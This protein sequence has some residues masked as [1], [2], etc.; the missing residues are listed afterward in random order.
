MEI[1]D[2]NSLLQILVGTKEGKSQVPV[3]GN[4]FADVLELTKTSVDASP[5]NSNNTKEIEFPKE[6]KSN[7]ALDSKKNDKVLNDNKENSQKV[8]NKAADGN[9]NKE[10]KAD[11]KEEVKEEDAV[12]VNQ[13]AAEDKS[14]EQKNKTNTDGI[15]EG[16][17]T[18]E[19]NEF[20]GVASSE[21]VSVQNVVVQALEG[22]VL[23]DLFQENVVA[24]DVVVDAFEVVLNPVEEL[25]VSEIQKPNEIDVSKNVTADLKPVTEEEVLLMEQAKYFDEKIVTDKKMKIEVNVLEEKIAEPVVKDVLKNRFEIDSMFQTVDD[26]MQVQVEDVEIVLEEDVENVV[27]DVQVVA[28]AD[29]SVY[30]KADLVQDTV[31]VATTKDIAVTTV[32]G[33]EVVAEVTNVSRNETFAKINETIAR[34]N[35]KGMS[36]EVIEQIKVNITKSAIKGVDTIDIQLKPEDLGKVQI[37]MYIGRDGKVQ[38]EIV[39]SRAETADMLQKDASMLSKAFND[40]GY[41]T[42][43]KSFTFSFQNENQAKGQE[44]EDSGLLKFIGDTLEQEA[45]NIAGNDNLGYDPVLGLNIRV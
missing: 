20:E 17:E 1:Q 13:T 39:A 26:D 19:L 16:D 43:A 34:D 14:V 21:D 41:D 37:K 6:V 15:E 18:T 40:A 31:S 9:K 3:D 28:K 5:K 33:K 8:E 29:N 23:N 44:R 45:E 2:R 22:D 30:V 35:Y 7:F 24:E 25:N 11:K 42:D 12:A 32:S 4:S 10:K 36:K 38:A 27:E